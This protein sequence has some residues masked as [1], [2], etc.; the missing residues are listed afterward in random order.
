MANYLRSLSILSLNLSLVFLAGCASSRLPASA[1]AAYRRLAE[2]YF[3]SFLAWRPQEGTSLGL[4][5]YDGRLSD[6]SRDSLQ[7]EHARLLRYRD[8]L[9]RID[10][11]SLSPAMS[12]EC[13]AM[14]AAVESELMGFEVTHSFTKNP[15][16]YAGRINLI[17]YAQREF[18]PKPRRL[19]SVIA[20]LD[21]TPALFS[22]ARANLEPR[23]CRTFIET[24]I[25]QADG[26]AEFVE[27]DLVKAFADVNDAALQEQ[28]GQA[29][30]QAATSLRDF[31][32]WLARDRLPMASYEFALGAEGYARML[33][34]CELIDLTPQQ[35]LEVG[36]RELGRE[37]TAFAAAARKIDSSKSVLEVAKVVAAE[38][39]TEQSLIPETRKHLEAIRA[40]VIARDLVGFPSMVPV[41]VEETPGFQ[42]NRSFAM[43]DTPGPFENSSV[44]FYYVTP[45]EPNWDA[46][47]K[48]EWL[49]AFNFYGTDVTSIHEAYPGHYLQFLRLRASAASKYDKAFS[50]YA[51]GEGWAH[52]CEQLVIDEG[53]PADADE[54]TR[55]KYRLSQ[56]QDALLRL[57][58]LCCSVKMHCQGMTVDEA[59]R[60]FIDN[61]YMA[62]APARQEAVRGTWDPGYGCYTLGKLQI[63]KLRDDW[64]RQEGN[65]FSL[66][67]FHEMILDHGQPPIRL[68]RELLLN[69]RSE[70]PDAL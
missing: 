21:Q 45:V 52:Y 24:A 49:S 54:V 56:S 53:Y 29:R 50:S 40:F 13:R 4:H 65:A 6:Y 68:L 8:D 41:R 60:F 26:A 58:R 1:D 9:R 27:N 63:L 70:W 32:Q 57:C 16:S 51:F 31:S 14:L 62:E 34:T 47:K 37:Q 20:I 23:L 11:S 36:L 48:E 5:Q 33:K 46:K 55:A 69:D 43:M 7:Q 61:A 19:A 2:E 38:H 35:V 17:T 64:R 22:S 67:R 42:R 3:D 30:K 66:R 12:R 25:R 10:Q 18:A 28:F 39:P 15:M 44:A 59:T